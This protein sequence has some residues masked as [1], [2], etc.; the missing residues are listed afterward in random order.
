MPDM[1]NDIV[2]CIKKPLCT[3]TNAKTADEAA[4]GCAQSDEERRVCGSKAIEYY[5]RVQAANGVVKPK[6]LE[7]KKKP[8][9]KAKKKPAEKSET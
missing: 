7:T 4:L 3:K 6:L 1:P 9:A 8:V 2:K 5:G